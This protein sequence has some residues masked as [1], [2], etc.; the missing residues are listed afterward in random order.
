MHAS[1]SQRTA[2]EDGFWR[3]VFRTPIR[4]SAFASRAL[5]VGIIVYCQLGSIFVLPRLAILDH[6]LRFEFRSE[7]LRF[8]LAVP[9]VCQ[10]AA[11]AVALAAIWTMLVLRD[12]VADRIIAALFL[13]TLVEIGCFAYA[14]TLGSGVGGSSGIQ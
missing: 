13:L 2:G 9:T 5:A 1:I 11:V 8:M 3:K 7:L 10:L 12:K 6:S 4:Y 14:I